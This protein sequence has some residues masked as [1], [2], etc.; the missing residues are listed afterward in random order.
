MSS[1][2]TDIS[3]LMGFKGVKACLYG[4]FQR[5]RSQCYKENL[6]GIL[7]FDEGHP[8][9]ISHFRRATRFLP[10]GSKKR[11]WGLGETTKNLPLSMFPKDANFKSSRFSLFLQI[12]DL[13]AYAARVKLESE[14]GFLSNKRT[15]RGHHQI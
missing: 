9:Y 5:L 4:L 2:A 3:D 15:N 13:V 8:E 11:A 14:L 7:F 1:Y 10:T 12:A 6:N